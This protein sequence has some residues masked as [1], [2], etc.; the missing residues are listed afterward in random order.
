[1]GRLK[2]IPWN[3]LSTSAA[4]N[5]AVSFFDRSMA[6]FSIEE[7]R[8]TPGAKPTMRKAPGLRRERSFLQ[9]LTDLREGK[10]EK[11]RGGVQLH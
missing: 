5:L 7:V 4:T 11:L 1:M 9:T 10:K 6:F 2:S 8:I 3:T